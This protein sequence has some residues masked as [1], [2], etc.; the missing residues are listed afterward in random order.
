[1]FRQKMEYLHNNPVKAGY[2]ESPEDYRWS[3]A[4]FLMSGLWSE[5][6]GLAYAEVIESLGTWREGRRSSLTERAEA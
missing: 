3:S 1:M 2:V 4:R 5:E 6:R